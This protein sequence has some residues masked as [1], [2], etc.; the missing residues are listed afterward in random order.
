MIP[1]WGY[2]IAAGLVVSAIFWAGDNY[3]LNAR[4]YADCKAE[5]ERRNADVAKVNSEEEKRHALEEEQRR[6][7][8]AKFS[9]CPKQQCLVSVETA[10]C[11]NGIGE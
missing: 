7:E 6:A 11:L 3:G 2:W 8:R 1:W 10:G 5:T 4:R 9:N